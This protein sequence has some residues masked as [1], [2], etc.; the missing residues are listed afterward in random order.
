MSLPLVEFRLAFKGFLAKNSAVYFPPI[1]SILSLSLKWLMIS[2]LLPLGHMP[3]PCRQMILIICF[4]SQILTLWREY[5]CR[6]SIPRFMSLIAIVVDTSGHFGRT[7]VWNLLLWQQSCNATVWMCPMD[8]W[9]SLTSFCIEQ[10]SAGPLRSSRLQGYF[11]CLAKDGLIMFREW[12]LVSD[13][14]GSNMFDTLILLCDWD[15]DFLSKYLIS[16]SPR[17][18][19]RIFTHEAM[20]PP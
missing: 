13:M 17:W 6:S 14:L 4:K 11:G 7:L 9:K 2:V 3:A 1:L 8:L 16:L 12:P 10:S 5:K 15:L 18:I 19:R 20:D